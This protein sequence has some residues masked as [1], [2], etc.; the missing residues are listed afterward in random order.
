MKKRIINYTFDKTAK[1][2]TFLDY[3]SIVL[4]SILLITNVKEGIDIFLF[5]DATKGGTISGNVL[6]LEYDTTAMSNSDPLLILIYNDS[7]AAS[8]DLQELVLSRLAGLNVLEMAQSA[9]GEIKVVIGST[10]SSAILGSISSVSVIGNQT[11]VGGNAANT[12]VPDSM[13]LG[14]IMGNINNVT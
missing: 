5:D 6:T 7:E 8:D 3:S 14:A 4:S 11:A 2:I 1:T 9:A 12:I 13:N 10:S